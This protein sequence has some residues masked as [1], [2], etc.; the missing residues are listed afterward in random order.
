MEKVYI[1]GAKRSAIGK[2]LGTLSTAD[3][4]DVCSQVIS[5]GFPGDWLKEVTSVIIGNVVSAGLGQGVARQIALRAG[6]PENVPA[7]TVGMVCGSG[8]QAVING[9]NEVKL[10]GGPVLVGGFEMM[11]QA[12]YA[13]NARVRQ[14]SRMGDMQLTDLMIRDGLT[15]AYSGV[16]MGVTAENI[17]RDLDITREEQDAYA[18][19]AIQKSIRAVDRGAFRE[20]IVP[21]S[22][23]QRK[24]EILFDTDEFPNRAST[25]EKLAALRPAFLPGGTVTAGNASGLN[26]GCAFLLLASE[27]WCK[28]HGVSPLCEIVRTAAVGCD[29]QKMGLGPAY[30]IPRLLEGTGM[31]LQDI[32]SL[33]LNEAFAAQALG[34]IRM[35][36]RRYEIPEEELIARTNA[37]GSGLGLGHPLG[38]TGARLP[39]TLSYRMQEEEA[40]FGIASLC[41]GGGMGTAMLLQRV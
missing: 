29:P 33:E 2:F 40:R 8:M 38:A 39:V 26:D 11:S 6:V 25:P 35:L 18:Y 21:V 24:G 34:C 23:P 36:S 16:H 17:A 3:P 20:E 19:E 31:T 1:A 12:P 5:K 7:Y 41:V 9:F 27:S 28:T 14:G 13:L 22:V 37:K 30:A 15:D 4:V 10:F 32:Q